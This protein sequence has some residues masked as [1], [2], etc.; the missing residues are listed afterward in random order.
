MPLRGGKHTKFEGGSRI[1]AALGGGVLPHALRG[2]ASPALSHVSDWCAPDGR[3]T[4][5][6]RGPA[7]PL[8]PLLMLRPLLPATNPLHLRPSL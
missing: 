7:S 1:V 4:I 8:R 2:V 6:T 3:H 5:A